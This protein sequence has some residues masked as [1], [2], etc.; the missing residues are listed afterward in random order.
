MKK[1]IAILLLGAVFL[2]EQSVFGM[3]KTVVEESKN[4]IQEATIFECISN[5]LM[6]D[7]VF[8]YLCFNDLMRFKGVKKRYEEMV[9][10]YLKKN[11][12]NFRITFGKEARKDPEK[13]L[14]FFRKISAGGE[15][16]ILQNKLGM[17]FEQDLRKHIEENLRKEFS[18]NNPLDWRLK[19]LKRNKSCCDHCCDYCYYT[20]L[21]L[22]CFLGA[23]FEGRIVQ[24]TVFSF[25]FICLC[26]RYLFD[27][28]DIDRE[29]EEGRDK[30]MKK[31]E[32]LL[33][34]FR[35]KFYIC[36]DDFLKKFRPKML[37]QIEKI[38]SDLF[39]RF[40]S[41][42]HENGVKGIDC[43][44][45]PHYR[46]RA[47][48]IQEKVGEETDGSRLMLYQEEINKLRKEVDQLFE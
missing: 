44:F 38:Y 40:G 21:M 41:A 33:S 39:S 37:R 22:A 10:K 26:L 25:L 11:P 9:E 35:C 32:E 16:F 20:V 27:H 12:R 28:Y 1:K 19:R 30:R 3:M 43:Y 31:E 42:Y 46:R 8:K 7:E 2:C 6:T 29:G 17:I 23:L 48:D 47:E 24:I 34:A 45:Q 4:E 15:K 14:N 5:E 36:K 18:S 13:F